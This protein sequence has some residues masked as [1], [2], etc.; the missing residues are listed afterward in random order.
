MTG[1]CAQFF[2]SVIIRKL[3]ASIA[4][5]RQL[6]CVNSNHIDTFSLTFENFKRSIHQSQTIKNSKAPTASFLT[7]LAL[8]LISLTLASFTIASSTKQNGPK[9]RK[10]LAGNLFLN[11]I[12]TLTQAQHAL[13]QAL[14]QAQEQEQVEGLALEHAVAQAQAFAQALAQALAVYL[15]QA[16]ALAQ[17]LADPDA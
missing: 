1:G 3:M 12:L 14:A 4:N 15:A 7:M 17:A 9:A 13:A 6:C 16:Q 5:H 8:L 11:K 2:D 10:L